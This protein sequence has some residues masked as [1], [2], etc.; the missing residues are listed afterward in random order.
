M[1]RE[2]LSDYVSGLQSE[3]F[4]LPTEE[5]VVDEEL[6]KRMEREREYRKWT[7]VLG[8]SALAL[9]VLVVAH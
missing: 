4:L 6:R 3:M 8:A 7:L 2:N 1:E 5:R 9:F